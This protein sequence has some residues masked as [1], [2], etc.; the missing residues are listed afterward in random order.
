LLTEFQGRIQRTEMNT[1][2]DAG[3]IEEIEEVIVEI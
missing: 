1:E 3:C 2:E